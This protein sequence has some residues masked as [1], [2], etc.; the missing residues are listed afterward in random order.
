[1]PQL[2]ALPKMPPLPQSNDAPIDDT[3]VVQA[4]FDALP[5]PSASLLPPPAVDFATM[6][7]GSVEQIEAG[8]ATGSMLS[9]AS[10]WAQENVSGLMSDESGGI[11]EKLSGLKSMLGE[12]TGKVF[13]SLAVVL[14][15]YFGFVWLT[16]LFGSGNRRGIPREVID[17]V[18]S[19]PFGPQKSLQLVRLGSKL[20]LLLT[21][22]EGTQS[23]GEVS[24][25][26][27]VAHLIALCDPKAA[28][29]SSTSSAG[30]NNAASTF[31][32]PSATAI[33]EALKTMDLRPRT[34]TSFQA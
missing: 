28:R 32:M 33:A 3:R 14:G 13:G 20:L 6:P 9:A 12:G 11:G 17:V 15:G 2:R 21:T 27:E 4:S 22:P 29:G 34:G 1:M 5:L 26:A 23:V 8:N 10:S 31:T 7:G 16:R 25:P 18:G 30:Q 19:T 24:D